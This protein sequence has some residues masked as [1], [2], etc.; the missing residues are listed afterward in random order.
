VASAVVH[1]EVS[2]PE[3][4]KKCL[5]RLSVPGR[6]PPHGGN[7]VGFMFACI[8]RG[9]AFYDGTPNVESRTFSQLYPG[10]PLFGFFGGGEIGFDFPPQLSADVEDS[11]RHVPPLFHSYSSIFVLLTF[12]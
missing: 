8:G 11:A 7:S 9:E 12:A 10:V 6:R 5:Q 1:A 4:V 2:D 3:E